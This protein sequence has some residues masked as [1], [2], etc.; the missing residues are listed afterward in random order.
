MVYSSALSQNHQASLARFFPPPWFLSVMTPA[1]LQPSGEQNPLDNTYGSIHDL[2]AR[3]N[4]GFKNGCNA[5][6]DYYQCNV[7]PFNS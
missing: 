5:A 6:W 1:T 4:L 3:L 2:E 7:I